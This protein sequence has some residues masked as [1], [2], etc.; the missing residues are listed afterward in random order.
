MKRYGQVLIML[1]LYGS[2]DI[3]RPC[4]YGLRKG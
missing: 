2:D 4:I 1:L 3:E